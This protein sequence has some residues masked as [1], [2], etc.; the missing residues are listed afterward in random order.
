MKQIGTALRLATHRPLNHLRVVVFAALLALPPGLAHADTLSPEVLDAMQ[1][2]V[3]AARGQQ[4]LIALQQFNTALDNGPATPELLFNL[5]LVNDRMGG[6]ELFAIAW[7]RAY[8]ASVPAADNRDQVAARIAALDQQV[9]ASARG[10]IDKA[11]AANAQM[12]INDRAG[13]VMAIAGAQARSGDTAA[14]FAT[15]TGGV[16]LGTNYY[17][18]DGGYSTVASSF[19]EAGNLAAAEEAVRHIVNADSRDQTLGNV[20]RVLIDHGD[21]GN[22]LAYADNTHG[23]QRIFAF[24]EIAKAQAKA[25]DKSGSAHSLD[26]ATQA[27][28]N[29]SGDQRTGDAHI[30]I[31]AAGDVGDADRAKRIYASIAWTGNNV[32]YDKSQ[33][34]YDLVCA[35]IASHRYGEANALMPAISPNPKDNLRS[36]AAQMF[37]RDLHTRISDLIESR[38]FAEA[39]QAFSYMP[40]IAGM[41]DFYEIAEAYLSLAYGYQKAGDTAAAKRVLDRLATELPHSLNPTP[42][43]SAHVGSYIHLAGAYQTNGD[44]VTATR[45]LDGLTAPATFAAI[46]KSE[47]GRSSIADIAH[48]YVY[49]AF[50]AAGKNDVAV[51]QSLAAKAVKIAANIAD[52]D[53]RADVLRLLAPQALKLNIAVQLGA[54]GFGS[55]T[56][57]TYLYSD[58]V[59]TYATA[60]D[61]GKAAAVAAQIADPAARKSALINAIIIRAAAG[62]W[63]SVRTL[64]DVPAFSAALNATAAGEM[65]SAGMVREAQALEPTFIQS[66]ED[67]RS[68]LS[69][70]ADKLANSGDFDGAMRTATR[71]AS[72]SDRVSALLRIASVAENYAGYA[73]A[74]DIVGRAL[75]LMTAPTDR[76][77]ICSQSYLDVPDV[78]N[79]PLSVATACLGDALHLAKREDSVN[80]IKNAISLLERSN[81]S[82]PRFLLARLLFEGSQTSDEYARHGDV[83]AALSLLSYDGAGESYNAYW[84]ESGEQKEVDYWRGAVGALIDAG[85]AAGAKNAIKHWLD[86]IDRDDNWARDVD[87]EPVV[88]ALIRLGDLDGAEALTDQITYDSSQFDTLTTLAGAMSASGNNAGKAVARIDQAAKLGRRLHNMYYMSTSLAFY[89]AR[90]G[91]FALADSLIAEGDASYRRSGRNSLIQMMLKTGRKDLVPAAIA[92]QETEFYHFDLAHRWKDAADFATNLAW[93]GDTPRLEKLIAAAPDAGIAAGILQGAAIGYVEAGRNDAAR[94][95]LKRMLDAVKISRPDFDA[96]ALGKIAVAEARVDSDRAIKDALSIGDG[97]LRTRTIGDMATWLLANEQPKSATMLLQRATT[98]PLVDAPL[99]TAARYLVAHGD[100]NDAYALVG[101]ISD[102]SERDHVRHLLVLMQARRGEIDA[103]FTDAGRVEDTAERGYLLA[104]LAAL[105]AEQ[106]NND[107]AEFANAA[108]TKIAGAIADP[109]VKADLLTAIAHNEQ[110]LG[111]NAAAATKANALA[112]AQS[113]TDPAMRAAELHWADDTVIADTWSGDASVRVNYDIKNVWVGYIKYNMDREVYSGVDQYVQSLASK[114]ARTIVGSL[115]GAAIDLSAGRLHLAKMSAD[116]AEKHKPQTH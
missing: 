116:W 24:T 56:N 97:D 10:L 39:E 11:V 44:I 34:T 33:T 5:A 99:A 67:N 15:V 64:A 28:D 105:L 3:A 21:L 17:N 2:G 7:Y 27:L 91:D 102:P 106:R 115:A 95:A 60:G 68:Y 4:W 84:R 90:A 29:E 12:P 77:Q 57:S 69:M 109:I 36:L 19:A 49:L 42:N 80:A 23:F 112:A 8:L 40:H 9:Q 62:D 65:L 96:W 32:A 31:E 72:L 87:R 83:T 100:A 74:K 101:K 38:K 18:P 59:A 79:A 70:L 13:G 63:Q 43:E 92:K 25:N 35:L 108:A 47:Y 45:I 94:D 37:G 114:D 98:S 58:M 26:L 104:D 51:A 73:K 22:A 103:A 46:Q 14:A 50:A 30:V 107:K 113:I 110:R 48:G 88:S 86:A 61:T 6:R 20:V 75:T 52:G 111:S 78:G 16:A 81:R 85:D 89:A 55:G 41:T 53:Q 76:A 82:A 93:A 1:K 71:Q 66:T 54:P